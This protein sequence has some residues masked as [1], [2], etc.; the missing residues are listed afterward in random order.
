MQRI[1]YSEATYNALSYEYA[2]N[3]HDLKYYSK[4][5]SNSNFLVE[6]P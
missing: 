4:S 1:K 2:R 3:Y 5:H 6:E